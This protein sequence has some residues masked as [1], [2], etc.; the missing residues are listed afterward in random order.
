MLKWMILLQLLVL[1]FANISFAGWQPPVT[2]VNADW[3]S[4]TGQVKTEYGDSGNSIPMGFC[5][6]QSGHIVV[7][8]DLNARVQVY[9]PTG[10][11]MS[12]F[13]ANIKEDGK[14]REQ[15]PL[16]LACFS[17]GIYTEYGRVSQIYDLN[18]VAIKNWD[19]MKSG[20]RKI[21]PD[22][23][24]VTSNSAAY[25]KYSKSGLL[26]QT[27]STKP[28]E[29][30]E[31]IAFDKKSD[32]NY[33]SAIK[34]DDITYG[35]KISADIVDYVRDTSGNLNVLFLAGSGQADIDPA[36]RNPVHFKVNKYNKCGKVVA[37]VDIPEDVYD[38][39]PEN[40]FAIESYLEPVI[41]FNSDVYV[42]KIADNY[43]ILKWAWQ[44]EPNMQSG[45]DAP[46]AIRIKPRTSG[47]IVRWDPSPQDPGCA[48]GYEI[49]RSVT[50]GGLFT[51]LAKVDS[52]KTEYKDTT[53][54]AGKTYY[55]KV[56]A[57]SGNEYSPYTSEISGKR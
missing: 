49:S 52:G 20:I 1:I 25:F 44:D 16:G 24:F 39:N 42:A 2:V 26:L 36:H 15:W 18:G 4:F 28:P 17:N 8:D 19:E 3:G 46:P 6:T 21:L 33:K 10:T 23:S 34:F 7:G 11:L 55:Y 51:A 12:I 32:G 31:V 38:E 56:R 57:F 27:Y 40:E 50:S 53:A 37:S 54:E 41:T 5:V 29:L 35:F 47:I 43:S 45:P 13:G 22:D 30:G 14:W 9:K 48:T